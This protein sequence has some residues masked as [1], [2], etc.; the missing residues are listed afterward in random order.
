MMSSSRIWKALDVFSWCRKPPRDETPDYL[1]SPEIA[2]TKDEL[3]TGLANF[4]GNW[5]VNLDD[6]FPSI[7]KLLNEYVKRYVH[8][9][10]DFLVVKSCD[11]SVIV[12]PVFTPWRIAKENQLHDEQRIILESFIMCPTLNHVPAT[13]YANCV[14]YFAD[15]VDALIKMHNE[16]V[17]HFN[18]SLAHAA[19]IYPYAATFS[20]PPVVLVVTEA[21]S[22]LLKPEI[23]ATLPVPIMHSIFIDHVILMDNL[24]RTSAH[25]K[26][27][28]VVLEGIAKC[29][30]APCFEKLAA[31]SGLI[32]NAAVDLTDT[33][34]VY[35][36]NVDGSRYRLSFETSLIADADDS[37]S[38]DEKHHT[39]SDGSDSE[40]ETHQSVLLKK[41]V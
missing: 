35:G 7:N 1:K 23:L 28:L 9:G 3:L 40:E 22:E 36:K 6:K 20:F 12:E 32:K 16:S 30:I 11:E 39:A 25:Q 15:S 4:R 2:L 27:D 29:I 17:A 24:Y 18:E 14:I 8:G 37:S 21:G 33:M 34:T 41:S 26:L 38:E 13:L 5:T 19:P 10:V 31:L